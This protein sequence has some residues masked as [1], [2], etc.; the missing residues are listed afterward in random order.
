MLEDCEW[1]NSDNYSKIL[2]K[3]QDYFAVK[4]NLNDLKTTDEAREV[5]KQM[6]N[7]N[8]ICAL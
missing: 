4:A 8:L 2:D 3:K 1:L 5:L 6:S 7:H